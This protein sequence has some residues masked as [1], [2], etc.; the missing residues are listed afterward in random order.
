MTDTTSIL[1]RPSV[2]YDAYIFDLDGTVYLGDALLP[3]AGETIT[4][5]REMGR[6]TV[7]LSNNPTHT[8]Q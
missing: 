2:L 5:L 4:T 3:A 6:R 8:Q 1:R 7:F